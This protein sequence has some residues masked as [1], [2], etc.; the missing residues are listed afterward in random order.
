MTHRR[1]RLAAA[2]ALVAA[3]T[4]AIVGHRHVPQSA[5]GKPA[6]LELAAL[7]L[8]TADELAERAAE[9]RAGRSRPAVSTTTTSSSSTT[10]T[11]VA[12]RR[13]VGTSSTTSPAVTRLPGVEPPAGDVWARL[14]QCEAGGDYRRN[15]G[16]GYTGAYQFEAQTWLGVTR[17]IG[18][19]H[20]EGRRWVPAWPRADLA[21]P[22][23]QDRAAAALQAAAGWGKW[24]A[25]SRRLGLR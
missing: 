23:V 18:A 9:A 7:P 19:G 8:P 17:T 4:P 21:P 24:P 6:R 3:V 1:A 22:E 2:L 20:L 11:T 12:R 25:C 13:P 14:R 15:T 16:N 10:S 5:G